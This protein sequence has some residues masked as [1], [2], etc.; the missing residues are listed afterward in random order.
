VYK[1]LKSILFR[2]DA[3]K[4][5]YFVMNG[6]AIFYKLPFG[7][8]ILNGLYGT[9]DSKHNVNLFGLQFKNAIGL[10]AGF[11]KNGKYIDELA[12]L[13]FGFIEVGTVTP[14]AQDGNPKPRL[15]RLP[16][17][18]AIIN[19]MGFNNDGVDQLIE[20]LKKVKNK[21]IVIGGNIGKNKNTPNE[22]AIKDYEICF[23]KLYDYVHYFVINVS[24]P[25]T[26]GLREL[27]DKEPLTNL[28]N[29]L[30]NLRKFHKTSKPIL[31]KIAPD[32]TD[33]QLNDIAQICEETSLDGLIISNTTI[34]RKGLLTDVSSV[35]EMGAGGLS[36][37]PLLEKSNY[38][39]KYVSAKT[40][41][42]IIG[43]GGILTG[44]DVQSK[45]KSGASL[46]QIYSGFIYQ[47]PSMVRDMLSKNL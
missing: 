7:K 18:E 35:E 14:L 2:F 10:A 1:I 41:K 39:L 11:D 13:G 17:D 47:G 27:Q 34:D 25:N 12:C 30:I 31:L 22:D 28:I 36:G 43:V 16:Q 9:D 29:A 44:E 4:V 33:D 23:E 5:H 24:S 45:M 38:A 32:L 37:K 21:Q 46:V 3:E 19:R 6:L 26:P 15:F 20:N 40:S 8:T 42:P